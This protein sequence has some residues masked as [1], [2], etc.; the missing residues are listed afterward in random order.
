MNKKYELERILADEGDVFAEDN[1]FRIRAVRDIPEVG[2]RA[3]EFGGVVSGNGNL[4][5]QGFCWI[6]YNAMAIEAARVTGNALIRDHAV[7]AENARVGGN[8][9]VADMANVTLQ[10]VVDGNATVCGSAIVTGDAH[11][12]GYAVVDGQCKIDGTSI[13]VVE[14]N[15]QG[16]E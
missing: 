14:Y 8:A 4:S 15:V 2:V 3:G 9:T 1:L 12:G 6:T 7:I 11:V 13:L 10:G 16:I 5:Q